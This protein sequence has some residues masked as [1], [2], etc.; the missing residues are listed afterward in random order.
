MNLMANH[1]AARSFSWMM[2]RCTIAGILV[3]GSVASIPANADE[4]RF[5]AAVADVTPTDFPVSSNGSMRPRFAERS[6]DPLQVRAMV[7]SS[8]NRTVALAVVDACMIPREV[9]LPACQVVSDRTGIP[10][11]AQ[12]IA[13][14][15]TH[16]AVTL[17]AAFQSEAVEDYLPRLRDGIVQAI[18]SAHKN[19]RPA[20]IAWGVAYA[21]DHVYNRR[22]F[23][24]PGTNIVDPL[25]QGTDRVKMNPPPGHPTLLE[26]SGPVDPRMTLMVAR[27]SQNEDK[28]IGLLANYALHYVGGV[29]NTDLSADYF[30]AFAEAVKRRV[31]KDSDAFVAAMTNGTSGNINNINFF[32]RRGDE[33]PYENIRVVSEDLAEKA[34]EAMQRVQP[35]GDSSIAFAV[36]EVTVGVRKP[37]PPEVIAAKERLNGKP[38]P[39]QDITD[40]YASETID[41]ADYPDHVTLRLHAFRIGDAAIVSSP[42]ETFVETGLAVTR[43]S[44]FHPTIV[45]ELAGGYHGYLPTPRHHDLGGYE[46]WRA[47]SSYLAVD[48]EPKIRQAMMRLLGELD[49]RRSE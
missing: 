28:P 13:A 14:T 7:W 2:I 19:L 10:I 26:P 21:P 31:A 42:C 20:S 8:G 35:S 18:V 38:R 3:V 15:H 47:K 33:R 34:T 5:G 37:T 48:A 29:P 39:L 41:L 43:D 45:V 25:G 22:W 40:I 49:Q 17:N 32:E 4:L 27:D 46:T 23:L 36:R 12:L 11:D 6:H 1:S 16:S 30:G 24:R 44:P 9:F